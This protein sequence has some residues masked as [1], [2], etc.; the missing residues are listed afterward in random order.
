MIKK[1]EESSP[2]SFVPLSAQVKIPQSCH[3]NTEAEH[4]SKPKADTDHLSLDILMP[5]QMAS[6]Q[7]ERAAYQITEEED[8]QSWNSSLDEDC[9]KKDSGVNNVSV[10]PTHEHIGAS[11]IFIVKVTKDIEKYTTNMVIQ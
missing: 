1:G 10:A 5:A 9:S 3:L 2:S 6:T 8:A 7:T 11:F 4:N